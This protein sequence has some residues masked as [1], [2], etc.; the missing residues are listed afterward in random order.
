M[1]VFFW[2]LFKELKHSADS[3]MTVRQSQNFWQFHL[4]YLHDFA[5]IID[6]TNKSPWE[7][8]SSEGERFVKTLRDARTR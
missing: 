3:N 8:W 7:A 2:A 1:A 4:S 5:A 6:E